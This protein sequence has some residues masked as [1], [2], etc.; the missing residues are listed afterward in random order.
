MN[1]KSHFGRVRKQTNRVTSVPIKL[2]NVDK[3]NGSAFTYISSEFFLRWWFSQPALEDDFSAAHVCQC[4]LLLLALKLRF[5]TSTWWLLRAC[6]FKV[7]SGFGSPFCC[8][9]P[10]F[11]KNQSSDG[12]R[13]RQS[14]PM[15]PCKTRGVQNGAI[16]LLGNYA[17]PA[18]EEP[19][20]NSTDAGW[21][22]IIGCLQFVFLRYHAHRE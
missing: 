4:L 18:D 10:P 19:P 9:L 14:L 13:F 11:D 17:R 15:V 12:R 1:T 3:L 5:A 21:G 16:L 2:L 8:L 22:S 7:L 6:L 20:P